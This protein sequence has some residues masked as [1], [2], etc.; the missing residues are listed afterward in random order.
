MT[1]TKKLLV[2]LCFS[3]LSAICQ[4]APGSKELLYEHACR[5]GVVSAQN[6]LPKIPDKEHMYQRGIMSCIGSLARLKKSGEL[7]KE[8]Y[9]VEYAC[10]YSIGAVY[11]KY[12]FVSEILP[13]LSSRATSAMKDCVDNITKQTQSIDK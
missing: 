7:E 2:T 10:G 13:K 8:T 1:Q 4:A 12:G 5:Q 9:V 6:S 3:S 11:T